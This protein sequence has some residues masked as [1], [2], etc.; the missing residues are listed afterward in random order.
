MLEV[1]GPVMASRDYQPAAMTLDL[2]EKD[3]SLIT[4]FA[5]SCGSPTPL[6]DTV[7]TLYART[8]AERDGAD[9]T[10]AVFEQFLANYPTS[11]E[12]SE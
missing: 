5:K 10:A 11:A 9:D 12:S 3:L 4:S 2:W 7:K 6:F 8:R 1:R